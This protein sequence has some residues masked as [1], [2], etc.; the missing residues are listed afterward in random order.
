MLNQNIQYNIDEK[1]VEHLKQDLKWIKENFW[2]NCLQE[3]ILQMNER[4]KI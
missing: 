4:E 2:K 3:L 1:N